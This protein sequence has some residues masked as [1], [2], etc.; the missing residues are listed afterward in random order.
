M[1][2]RGLAKL[3]KMPEERL[4]SVLYGLLKVW[5]KDFSAG[6]SESSRATEIL[7]ILKA[8]NSEKWQRFSEFFLT[9]VDE[10]KLQS[11]LVFLERLQSL[12]VKEDEFLWVSNNDH[13]ENVAANKIPLYFVLDDIRSSFNIGSIFRLADCIGVS[14]I[15]LC[16][17]TASPENFKIEKAAMGAES[18]TAWEYVEDK[19][20]LFATLE[21]QGIEQVALETYEG[22]IDVEDYD[23][24]LASKT[25]LW[26]GNERF[27]LKKSL[28][29]NMKACVVLPLY[30]VKNSL[31]VA[32][33]L[34]IASYK[35]MKDIR[36]KGG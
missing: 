16:G 25:A 35:A 29:K 3:Q 22:A 2:G 27:G 17:Y 20:K 23:F 32:Q 31:N 34:S 11:L 15:Y 33:A 26:V 19:E 10:R 30:G 21:A 8:R 13:L 5:E 36:G 7:N 28:V 4:V 6:F 1:D 24:S 12:N 14:K 18:Y 9:E